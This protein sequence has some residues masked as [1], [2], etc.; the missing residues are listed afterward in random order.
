MT[1]ECPAAS[2]PYL[3]DKASGIEDRSESLSDTDAE[4]GNAVIDATPFHLVDKRCNQ[5]SANAP[6]RV[7]LTV[8]WL[9]SR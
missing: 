6:E 5:A 7:L 1:I 9:T 4:F 3:H 2:L 8:T